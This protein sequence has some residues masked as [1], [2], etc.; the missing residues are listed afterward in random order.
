[1]VGDIYKAAALIFDRAFKKE[2]SL[3]HLCYSSN[4]K[5]KKKLFVLVFQ[6]VKIKKLLEK[7]AS[8]LDDI[9]G[10]KKCDINLQLVLIYETVL[11]RRVPIQCEHHDILRENHDEIVDVYSRISQA[12]PHLLKDTKKTDIIFPRYVRVNNINSTVDE[13][14]QIFTDEGYELVKPKLPEELGKN[15]FYIDQHI[16]NLLSFSADTDLH[17]HPL[18]T[19]GKIQLQDKASCLPAFVLNPP[20]D[21]F[22]MDACAA[23]GNK[24]S[25]MASIIRNQGT[26]YSFDMDKNRFE[27]MNKLLRKA[28]ASCVNTVLKDFLKVRHDSELYSQVEY[29]LVDPSCSGSGIVSRMDGLVDG[30]VN[31]SKQT[32]RLKGLSG[33]QTAILSHA[34]S[35]PNVKKVVYSTCSIH[36]EENEDVVEKACE[37]FVS[38]FSLVDILPVW[39]NRGV[40]E[41]GEAHKCI[42]AVPESDHTNGF[43]VALFER[44]SYD[45]AAQAE[46]VEKK[47]ENFIKKNIK[48]KK[49]AV[50]NEKNENQGKTEIS[51]QENKHVKK[52]K[53]EKAVKR[54]KENND[55]VVETSS[56]FSVTRKKK[57]GGFKKPVTA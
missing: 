1:M 47:K 36:K 21:S 4:Y 49:E 18:Y 45:S 38:T 56:P 41:W 22:V 33:F 48:M 34:L 53:K 3:K 29:I 14:C 26:I 13:V 40:G 28:D 2:G 54:K 46:K 10:D 30:E 43:F 42:R 9:W 25:H 11:G 37:R 15:E 19:Q 35:F 39:T 12:H 6:T 52:K 8:E 23:P 24:S 50:V 51:N 5:N 20:P 16:P 32:Q 31:N 57:R 44:H 55:N 17:S 27:V 7:V